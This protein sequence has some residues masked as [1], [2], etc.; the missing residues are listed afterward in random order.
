MREIKFRGKKYNGEWIYGSLL[1][2]DDR[3]HIFPTDAPDSYDNYHVLPETVGQ[4]TGLKD[5]NGVE[6]YEGDVVR[7]R[8]AY[9]TTQ[10]HTGD[11]IPNGSYTEPMEPG[12]KVIEGEVFFSEQHLTW[13]LIDYDT[14]D[15]N[16]E[17][18]AWLNWP[19]TLNDVESAL[20][21]HRH[22]FI[23]DDP[24]EGDLQYLY[25][26]TESKSEEELL[27]YLNGV[28]IIGNIHDNPELINQ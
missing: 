10:T 22:G 18:L 12:I 3:A 23:F 25:E 21:M 11:N 24:E 15:E 7:N 28:E 16:F 13:G 1:V 2:Q 9:R 4:F 26:I 6:I 19:V 8:S 17:H 27:R 5:K 14:H 20:N